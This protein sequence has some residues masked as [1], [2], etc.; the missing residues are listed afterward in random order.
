MVPRVLLHESFGFLG[1]IHF[2]S[3]FPGD[4]SLYNAVFIISKLITSEFCFEN[5]TWR[6]QVS[7][8]IHDASERRVKFIPSP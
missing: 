6:L 8:V 4:S 3:K 5:P 1:N 2:V 7:D